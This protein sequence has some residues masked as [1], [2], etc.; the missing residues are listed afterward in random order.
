MGREPPL[1]SPPDPN[2]TPPQLNQEFQNSIV[3]YPSAANAYTTIVEFNDDPFPGPAAAWGSIT[4]NTATV[5]E[6]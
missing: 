5:P 2:A 4:F 1:A 3:Q 6:P